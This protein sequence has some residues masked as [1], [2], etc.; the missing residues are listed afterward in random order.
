M[1]ELKK[2][3]E[4]SL[5]VRVKD[6]FHLISYL[7]V[8]EGD[9]SE[10]RLTYFPIRGRAEIARLILVQ[11]GVDYQDIRIKSRPLRVVVFDFESSSSRV[12]VKSSSIESSIE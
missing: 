7:K 11:A 1:E 4:Q 2:R 5:K 8:E 3:L 10:I 6:S 12:V 9:L